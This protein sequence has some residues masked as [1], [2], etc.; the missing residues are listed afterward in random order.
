VDALDF[1]HRLEEAA[2]AIQQKWKS[3]HLPSRLANL[4]QTETSEEDIEKTEHTDECTEETSENEDDEDG[5]SI[6]TLIVLALFGMGMW[7]FKM[8]SKCVNNS[9][10]TGAEAMDIVTQSQGIGAPPVGAP[11]VGLPP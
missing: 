5:A 4:K 6:Y 9:D 10:D 11:Q 7:S 8:L 2:T 1:Q 3:F